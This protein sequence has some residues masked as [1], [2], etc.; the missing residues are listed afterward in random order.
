MSIC[1]LPRSHELDRDESSIF[2]LAR[3][4]KPRVEVLVLR[5]PE[6][7]VQECIFAPPS[8]NTFLNFLF[9]GSEHKYL[10]SRFELT[11]QLEDAG[12]VAVKFMAPGES[13]DAHLRGL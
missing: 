4:L 7:E 13:T 8:K 11:R 2:E 1:G 12:F 5:A 6:Q 9:R 3:K 10:Y